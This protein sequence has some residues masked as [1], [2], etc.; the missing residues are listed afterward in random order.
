MKSSTLEATTRTIKGKKV[1]TLRSQGLIPAVIYGHGVEAQSIAVAYQPF[2]HVYRTAGESSLIDLAVDKGKPVKV[3]IQDVTADP[4]TGRFAH[5]D[6][7]QVRLT[8]KLSTEVTLHFIGESKAVKEQGGILVKAL[9]HLRI[10]CLAQ[11][12]VHEIDVDLAPLIDFDHAI[13]VQDLPIPHGISVKQHPDEVVAL[14]QPPRSEE[15]LKALEETPEQKIEEI[16]VAKKGKKEEEGEE[17]AESAET[18]QT[19]KAPAAPP[20]KKEKKEKK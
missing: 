4:V 10:E 7:H 2:D 8:E 15:E 9:D 3:L 1:R 5:I 12:L 20:E 17:G 19:G 14:V 11:D 13:R 16:E 18:N 6:F